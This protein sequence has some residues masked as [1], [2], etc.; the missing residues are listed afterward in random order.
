MSTEKKTLEVGDELVE[1]GGFGGR[2]FSVRR[3]TRVTAHYAWAGEYTKYKREL[4]PGWGDGGRLDAKLVGSDYKYHELMTDTLRLEIQ[5]QR[6]RNAFMGQCKSIDFNKLTTE[7]LGAIA[8]IAGTVD[9][10]TP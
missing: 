8:G 5:E 10:P 2:M 9:A 4:T 6:K 7:Q 1:R 3:I